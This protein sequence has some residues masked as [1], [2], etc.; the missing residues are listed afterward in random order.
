MSNLFQHVLVPID[1][2]PCSGA[3]LK[4]AS[5][6]A[7]EHGA[8][9]AVLHATD[10]AP[11]GAASAERAEVEAFV[12]SVL[13]SAPVPHLLMATGSA[14][15]VILKV[16]DDLGCDVI[17]LGTHGRTGR[18]RMLAGSV[19]ESVMRTANCPVITVR[20]PS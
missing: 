7:R 16:A 6:L 12:R 10:A 13:A 1:L 9:L 4:L 14:R 17:V 20:D 5:Q 2:S 19:A 11:G 15:D 8:K 18:R 3:A